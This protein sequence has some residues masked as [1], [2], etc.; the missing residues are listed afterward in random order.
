[1]TQLDLPQ[2]S[3]QRYV[4]LLKRRRWQVVP[5]SLLGLLLGGLVAFFIPRYYVANTMLVHQ[6]APGMEAAR[7]S[8]DPFRSIV[9]SAKLTIPLAIGETIKRLDWPEARET[10]PF[11]RSESE[12]EIKSRLKIDDSNQRKDRDYAQ[13]MVE[14]K[15]RDGERA[16][17]FLNTLVTTWIELRLE[18][19]REQAEQERGYAAEAYDRANKAYEQLLAD[20]HYLEV[21]YGIDPQPDPLGEVRRRRL[22]AQKARADRL[23][24]RILDLAAAEKLLAEERRE[25][26][27]TDKRRPIAPGAPRGGDEAGDALRT[28]ALAKSQMLLYWQRVAKNFHDSQPAHAAA[29]KAIAQIEE[30]LKTLGVDGEAFDGTEPNPA[31]VELEAQVRKREVEVTTLRSAIEA[32]T[33][34]VEAEKARLLRLAEGY[35]QYDPKLERLEDARAQRQSLSETLAAK[36]LTLGQLQNKRT[37]TQ[38]AKA[39]P[40]PRPTDPNILVVALIG[41]VLGL[42]FAIGLILLLD[43]LQGSYKTIDEVERSLAVPVLGGMSHL[44]TVEQRERVQRGRRRMTLV[45]AAFLCLCVVVI[46]VFYIDPTRL[47]PTVRDLLAMLLGD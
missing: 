21:E 24:Q 43:V 32:L 37:I 19:Y 31:Y 41:C 2:I 5:A 30:E 11:V 8:E 10:D 17:A 26:L 23:E 44:E 46:T 38:P 18:Q 15:D 35:E 22:D 14:F 25:L 20:K 47:P 13:L 27:L 33:K 36:N 42:G 45:A 39:N 12:R 9:E 7:S 28:L 16:A 29:L 6:M 4:D 40:P 3:L 34:E 1:M